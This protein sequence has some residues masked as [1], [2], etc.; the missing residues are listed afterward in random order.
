MKGTVACSLLAIAVLLISIGFAV[1]WHLGSGSKQRELTTQAASA[2][3]CT[4]ASAAQ[5]KVIADLRARAKADREEKER[6]QQAALAVIA[7]RDEEIK[8]LRAEAKA[9]RDH[10]VETARADDDCKPLAQLPV[11]DAI[12]DRLWPAPKQ[13]GGD[14]PARNR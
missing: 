9:R 8:N 3:T 1:G 13:A 2:A 14:Q 4:D 11:C 10:I 12:A 7:G 6:Q 5:A